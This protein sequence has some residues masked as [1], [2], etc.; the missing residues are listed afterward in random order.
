MQIGIRNASLRQEPAEA[1]A[2]AGQLGFDGVELI[3]REAETLAHWLTDGGA[4]QVAAWCRHSRCAVSSL[5]LGPFRLVNFGLPD[6]DARRAGVALVS[7]SLRAC[8]RLGGSAVLVPHFDRERIDIGAEEE[9]RFVEE[10][11]RCVPA[12]EETGVAIA[13]EMSCSAAQLQRIVQTVGSPL[14]GVYQ[15]LANALIYG[16]DP[17]DMLRRLDGAVVMVHVKDTAPDGGNVMLGEGRVDWDGCRAALRAIGYD[18]WYVLETPPGDDPAAAAR[19]NLAFTRR[20]LA[21]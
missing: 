7:D 9:Q 6:A 1:L 4:A 13:L 17:V 18:G 19:Q 12:A 21:E 14:V 10:L 3:V 20:W 16:H 5:S 8:R 15:D 2:T 11:R